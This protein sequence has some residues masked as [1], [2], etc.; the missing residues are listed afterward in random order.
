MEKREYNKLHMLEKKNWYFVSRRHF[1][2]EI[3][4]RFFAYR[5]DIKILD[6]GCGSGQMFKS[7]SKYGKVVG[8]EPSQYAL[9]FAPK[10]T[11]RV[12]G[13]GEKVPLTSSSFDLIAA[14]GVLEH[15]KD[16]EQTLREMFR[17]SKKKGVVMIE[18]PAYQFLWSAHDMALHHYRRYTK[19]SL[20]KKVEKA[21]FRINK[22]G[23]IFTTIF[24][25]V[26]FL[27]AV[28][29]IVGGREAKTDGMEKVPLP[30]QKFL[31]LVNRLES[32]L[33]KR[34]DMPFGVS[35]FALA[36]KN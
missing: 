23:Y 3:L 26:V 35:V 24:P 29:K 28:K 1:F 8:V 31:I 16:D 12:C 4:E 6:L 9:K 30:I 7:L 5:K 14:F 21:G 33:A 13:D 34:F 36:E 27:R 17:L 2:L 25:A 22:A 18:V 15:I 20:V 10:D 19:K 11:L 32:K